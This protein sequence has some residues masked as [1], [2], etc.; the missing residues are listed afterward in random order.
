MLVVSPDESYTLSIVNDILKK[1]PG[2]HSG[3]ATYY[4]GL[5]ITWLDDTRE[6][7]L[8][9]AA[10]V[11]KLYEKFMHFMDVTKQRSLPAK[12]NLR[13]CKS[14]SNFNITSHELD[15]TIYKY[16]ELL[17]GIHTSLIARGRMPSMSRI[18]WLRFQTIPCGNIGPLHSRSFHS[19]TTLVFGV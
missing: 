16:R 13:I 17:G 18:N 11:E 12:E 19:F 10:H 8:T 15:V 6:V 4:N 5:R 7:L 3:R 1:L 9:Q 14:G 2:T